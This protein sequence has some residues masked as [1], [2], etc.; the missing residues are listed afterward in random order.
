MIFYIHIII[1]TIFITMYTLLTQKWTKKH[2][3]SFCIEYL[4]QAY[5]KSGPL[6]KCGP[7]PNFDQRV[8]LIIM[9]GIWPAASIVDTIDS[10]NRLTIIRSPH[11]MWPSWQKLWTPPDL[12]IFFH[13]VSV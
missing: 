9:N 13:R 4:D 2:C 11:H 10:T 5:P 3:K 1:I 8:A 6:A 7:R 12:D